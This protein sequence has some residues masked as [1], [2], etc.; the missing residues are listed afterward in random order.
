MNLTCLLG[1]Y[2][3]YCVLPCWPRGEASVCIESSRPGFDSCFCH[4]SVSGLSHTSGIKM[5][6]AVASLSYQWYKDG[7]CSG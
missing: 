7:Y 5:G 1:D 3:L 4:R 2:L 6:T